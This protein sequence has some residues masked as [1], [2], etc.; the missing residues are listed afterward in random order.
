MSKRGKQETLAPT[1]AD[2]RLFPEDYGSESRGA[3]YAVA[4]LNGFYGTN[5]DHEIFL[6]P[7][8]MYEHFKFT[9]DATV[10]IPVYQEVNY[11]PEEEFMIGIGL[12]ISF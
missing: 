9:L 5:G 11:R 7:G 6:S 12:R 8:I 1:N 2:F 3:L 10:M 4:E